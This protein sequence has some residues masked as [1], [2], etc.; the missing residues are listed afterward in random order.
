[1]VKYP[2]EVIRMK[3][4][5]SFT[6]HRQIK[7]EHSDKIVPLLRRAI[8]YAY[9]EGCRDFYAGGALGFDTLAAREVIRFRITHSDARLLLILPC[10]NQTEKWSASQVNA[11]DY[12][13]SNADEVRYVSEEY[14]DGCM[15][16]RNFALANAAD[17]LIAYV[18]RGAS[19]AAQTVRFADNLG[20]TVYNLY[21]TLEK[22]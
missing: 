21:P 15:R 18:G 11:Y 1:M 2:R 14:T 7:N 12:V 13:L 17:I 22:S 8:E 4:S 3:K 19:G 5:C 10:V 6:G 9:N 20:K 16:E